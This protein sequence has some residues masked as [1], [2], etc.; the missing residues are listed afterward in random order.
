MTKCPCGHSI[1]STTDYVEEKYCSY[2]CRRFYSEGLQKIPLS[3]YY[4]HK[5]QFKYP[6]I[7]HNC[8]W[9]GQAKE[10]TYGVNCGGNGNST[11]R[12]CNRNCYYTMHREG[13]R[14]TKVR[15]QLFRILD[16]HGRIHRDKI[17]YLFSMYEPRHNRAIHQVTGLLSIMCRRGFVVKHDDL[18]FEIVDPRPIGQLAAI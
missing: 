8:D 1:G 18:T 17:T 14:R 13:R 16:Q 12:F 2:Y 5:N 11:G 7:V 6:P 15:Y 4:K 9:C 10:I 3:N